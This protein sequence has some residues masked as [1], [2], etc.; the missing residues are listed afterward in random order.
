MNATKTSSHGNL[1]GK[2]AVITGASRGIGLA[3]GQALAAEGC[4]VVLSARNA[5]TLEKAVSSF[6]AESKRV[7]A[8]PCDVRDPGSVERLF[9]TVKKQFQKVDILINNA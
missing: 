6:K 4:H 8:E 2:T 9:N 5:A 7:V 1:N 3:I